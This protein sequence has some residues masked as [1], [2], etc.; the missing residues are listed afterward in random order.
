MSAKVFCSCSHQSDDIFQTLAVILK[1]Q[2]LIGSC[3]KVMT[4]FS[5]DTDPWDLGSLTLITYCHLQL[6]ISCICFCLINNRWNK[7]ASHLI[8][9]SFFVTHFSDLPINIAVPGQ[10]LVGHPV[11]LLLVNAAALTAKCAQ[12]TTKSS[13]LQNSQQGCSVIHL[14]ADFQ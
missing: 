6:I 5:M 9:A 12:N 1:W 14:H 4:V 3:K 10:N 11:F 2:V 7:T 13:N 8:P